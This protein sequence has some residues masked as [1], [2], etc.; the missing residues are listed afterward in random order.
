M[1]ERI[2]Q[3]IAERV[4][5]VHGIEVVGATLPVHGL[6]RTGCIGS[7]LISSWDLLKFKPLSLILPPSIYIF[8][9]IGSKFELARNSISRTIKPRY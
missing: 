3:Y 5:E 1:A 7:N 4:A 6:N 2:P 8:V 9:S